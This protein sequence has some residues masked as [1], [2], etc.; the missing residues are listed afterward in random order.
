[1]IIELDIE[2]SD[3]PDGST[4]GASLC[5]GRGLLRIGGSPIWY[6]GNRDVPEAIEWSWIELLEFVGSRWPYLTTEQSY[7]LGLAPEDPR[8]LRRSLKALTTWS[9]DEADRFDEAV[10]RF[11][12]NHDL[13]RGLH[14]ITVP[15]VFLLRCGQQLWVT[16]D[17]TGERYALNEVLQ[18][19]ESIGEMLH[20]QLEKA[21]RT[22]RRD[23]A[24]A[25][26][27]GRNDVDP[28]LLIRLT[29]GFSKRDFPDGLP[30]DD[31]NFWEIDPLAGADS[32][33]TA[34]ARLSG[35]NAS[36]RDRL[37]I[38]EYIRAQERAD[39]TKLD[40]LSRQLVPVLERHQSEPPFEQAYALAR[41]TRILLDLP[42]MAR[43]SPEEILDEI[44][45][46]V[47]EEHLSPHID[48]VGCWGPKHGPAIVLNRNGL[49][50][51]TE[52]GR[53]A[54][55]AHE[56]C[57]LLV[58]REAALPLAEVLDTSLQTDTEKR[59]RAFAA[60]L[61]LARPDA[62]EIYSKHNAVKPTLVEL[63]EVFGVSR[64]LAANQLRNS[65]PPTMTIAEVQLLDAIIEQGSEI[66]W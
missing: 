8:G 32:E 2:W 50:A 54:T 58:D 11:E 31:L 60:E 21:P 14:G 45:V 29:T 55:L 22:P 27:L 10:F 59:A 4:T 5:W 1:M 47:L 33:I 49:H 53:R 37:A 57:H 3:P 20:T 23:A 61:L 15:S 35:G 26:W 36:P 12:E 30:R 34:A 62:R 16:T 6:R 52:A 65:K 48:A 24:I 13:A 25:T 19:L 64:V 42:R 38:I 66:Y 18:S 40:D 56:L 43:V 17:E 7:P 46:E 44:N 28:R 39:T 51:S 63:Q 9:E 41:E